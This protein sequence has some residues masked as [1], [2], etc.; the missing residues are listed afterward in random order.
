VNAVRF[1]EELKAMREDLGLSIQQAAEKIGVVYNTFAR[2]ETGAY[3]PSVERQEEIFIQLGS[4]EDDSK[5]DAHLNELALIEINALKRVADENRLLLPLLR[6]LGCNIVSTD[7]G[8]YQWELSSGSKSCEISY[9]R[10]LIDLELIK[11][12][13]CTVIEEIIEKANAEQAL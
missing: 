3:L 13:M 1:G 2:Y 12:K 9:D 5:V 11:R 4:T 6:K 10:L 7:N 8:K